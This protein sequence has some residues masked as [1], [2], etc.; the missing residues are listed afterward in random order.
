LAAAE[1]RLG[2]SAKLAAEIADPRALFFDKH[3]AK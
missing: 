3:L 1:R 2:I